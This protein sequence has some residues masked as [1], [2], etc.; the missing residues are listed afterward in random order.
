MYEGYIRCYVFVRNKYVPENIFCSTQVNLS[1]LI[2]MLS[3]IA[4]KQNVMSPIEVEWI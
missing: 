3:F 4:D 1:L 2:V